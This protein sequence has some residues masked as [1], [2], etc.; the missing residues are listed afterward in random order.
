MY[1]LSSQ[2]FRGPVAS[3]IKQN[4]KDLRILLVSGALV[5]MEMNRSI[6]GRFIF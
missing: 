1:Q 2:A 5:N 3:V 6:K 4:N